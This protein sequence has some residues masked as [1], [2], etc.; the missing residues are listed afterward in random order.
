MTVGW[1]SPNPFH[2]DGTIIIHIFLLLMPLIAIDLTVRWLLE[3]RFTL[4]DHPRPLLR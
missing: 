1:L 3:G 4:A 2:T